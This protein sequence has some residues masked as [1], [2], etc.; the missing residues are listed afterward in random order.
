MTQVL[1]KNFLSSEGSREQPI[2]IDEE[3]ENNEYVVPRPQLTTSFRGTGGRRLMTDYFKSSSG[4]SDAN[5]EIII[6]SDRKNSP[7]IYSRSLKRSSSHIENVAAESY[8]AKKK[9][10]GSDVGHEVFR[11]VYAKLAA[12]FATSSGSNTSLGNN[13]DITVVEDSSIKFEERHNTEKKW[14][15]LNHPQQH[16]GI[17]NSKLNDNSSLRGNVSTTSKDNDDR[18]VDELIFVHETPSIAAHRSVYNTSGAIFSHL[19]STTGR[20]EDDLAVAEGANCLERSGSLDNDS[21]IGTNQGS[22]INEQQ[23]KNYRAYGKLIHLDDA[24]I[25]S[26]LS[27]ENL[28]NSSRGRMSNDDWDQASCKTHN[29]FKTV[30]HFV[31]QYDKKSKID[32]PGSFSGSLKPY[33]E[34]GLAFLVKRENSFPCG[35]ILADDM[36]LGKTAQMISL[37]LYQK[38]NPEYKKLDSVRSRI[39]EKKGLRP[40]NA[41]LIVA[42]SGLMGQWESEIKKFAKWGGLRITT[43]HGNKRTTNP[44]VWLDFDIIITSYGTVAA[45]LA[46]LVGDCDSDDDGGSKVEKTKGPKRKTP[47]SGSILAKVCFQRIILDEAHSIKNRKSLT[48]KACASLSGLRRWCVT[49]TP[50]HNDLWDGFS[51]FRFLRTDPLDQD[52]IWKNYINTTTKHGLCRLD[53]LVGAVLLRRTKDQLNDNGECLVK[54]PPRT[55]ERIT[56]DMDPK[57]RLIYDQMFKAAQEF[58][59]SFLDRYSDSDIGY[60]HY[61]KVGRSRNPFINVRKVSDDDDD[62]FQD[63]ACIL[64]LLLRLRQA[65]NHMSLTKEGL[66]LDCFDG[67]ENSIV[68]ENVLT[69][70]GNSMNSFLEENCKDVDSG[71]NHLQVFEDDF[72]SSKIVALF[73]RVDKIFNETE[74]KIIIVSQ[75]T[76]MLRLVHSHLN[77]RKI[78]F[79]EIT[80]EV[81]Q[82]TRHSAQEV[83]NSSAKPER[84]MLLSLKAGGVGLNLVGANHLF[85]L[86]PHWNPFMEDQAC[87]RIYRIGQEKNVFVHKFVCSD[88][89]EQRV[90]NLQDR[91]R[92]LS[93][94]FLKKAGHKKG[95]KLTNEDLAY[96]FEVN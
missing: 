1:G 88:S 49:G 17:S 23:L 9:K 91:K 81:D 37:I 59:R 79:V 33:Q 77:K 45:E 93:D 3:C 78:T 42:P 63:M 60:S 65:C 48:S 75:W 66:D 32:T 94:T 16:M 5:E 89:I 25:G 92:D 87:D 27:I 2:V 38:G 67:R 19:L 21:G 31:E 72:A 40:V 41:T 57:E 70:V 35:G 62:R 24:T 74:D 34:E 26:I 30:L 61:E 56:L 84:I 44:R 68:D 46:Y 55:C 47:S 29:L 96:L 85:I 53:I 82:K 54:L 12:D 64:V 58:V 86:D 80:G 13:G 11:S 28:N 73:E 20:V 10:V 50:I 83:I 39:A 51:L 18:K 6:L 15:S 43:F 76:S 36:G 69:T 71:K 7:R 22:F 95:Y 52:T 4:G 90:L 8:S 14:K